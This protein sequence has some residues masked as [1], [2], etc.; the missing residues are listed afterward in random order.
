M[1]FHDN[2]TA[3]ERSLVNNICVLTKNLVRWTTVTRRDFGA[4]SR[5][6]QETVRNP[7]NRA[8]Q[9]CEEALGPDHTST[10]STVNNLGNLYADQ[11]K[12]AEAEKMCLRALQ[13]H[14]E[15]LGPDHTS[16]LSMVNNLGELYSDQGKLVEA[17]AMF[18][19]ALQGF[20]EA[21]GPNHTSTLYT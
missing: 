11:G 10:L 21:L 5:D 3:N 15:A 18:T 17:E 7:F 12:L 16:T 14:E 4:L 9:G 2:I 13:G 6:N 19:R 1:Q 20:E 8:L